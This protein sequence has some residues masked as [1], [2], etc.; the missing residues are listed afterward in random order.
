MWQV[1]LVL[2]FNYLLKHLMMSLVYL[3]L[4]WKMVLN[5]KIFINLQIFMILTSFE[6]KIV[7]F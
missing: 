6:Q 4:K 5:Y 7:F 2:Y 3:L 1:F